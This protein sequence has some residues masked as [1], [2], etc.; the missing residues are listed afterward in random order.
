MEPEQAVELGHP[1]DQLR[2][3]G[4]R[5]RNF[6]V[7]HRRHDD[8]E[9]A[10]DDGLESSGHHKRQHQ[11]GRND[12]IKFKLIQLGALQFLHVELFKLGVEELELKQHQRIQLE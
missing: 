6:D 8:L 7:D 12:F 4:G 3:Y 5:R 1:F 9:R 2:R 11:Y 10:W